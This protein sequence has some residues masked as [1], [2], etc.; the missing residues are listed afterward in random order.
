MITKSSP[1]PLLA[2]LGLFACKEGG[3]AAD[4]AISGLPENKN[5]SEL[6][7]AE[8]EQL[9]EG[10]LAYTRREITDA[11]ANRALCSLQG[12]VLSS[13]LHDGSVEDCIAAR[14]ECLASIKEEPVQIE[15]ASEACRKYDWSDC[16]TTVGE[17]DAC[18]EEVVTE[19]KT[20]YEDLDCG[21]IGQ[22][23]DEMPMKEPEVGE[24]C[25]RVQ[26]ECPGFVPGD[27]L[28]QA[29]PPERAP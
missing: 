1:L 6:T 16:T 24:A 19:L 28:T 3:A 23:K 17:L 5:V 7:M 14:D 11:E 18:M 22:F 13:T 8:Q 21:N 27:L 2:L 29:K 4:S 20:F 12:I 9:C 10:A 15:E 26:N 25:S